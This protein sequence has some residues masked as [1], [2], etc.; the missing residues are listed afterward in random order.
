VKKA[1]LA[2]AA[3]GALFIAN[4]SLAADLGMR[5]PQVAPIPAFT[6]TGCYIGGHAGAGWSDKTVSVPSLVPGASVTGHT[7]GPLGGGQIG[8]DL[9]LGG[10]VIG[11]EGEGSAADIRGDTTQTIL[12]ITGTAHAE[13]TWLASATGRLGWAWDRWLIYAKGGAAWAGDK[14][15]LF[16][17][18]FPEQ[19]TASETRTGWI[20]GGGIEWAF[21][22]NWS[23]KVEYNYYD[24]GTSSVTLVGTFAGAPIEVPGV[25]I[26][27]RISVGKFGINYRF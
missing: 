21:W 22:N 4:S 17:P 23:A 25:E 15:S 8:C 12:G 10:W 7:F 18:V 27:Q 26:R 13:T 16:I 20:V 11:I 14:Y 1:L 2:S 9:Q 24:F 5:A 19:E 6:W 3:L